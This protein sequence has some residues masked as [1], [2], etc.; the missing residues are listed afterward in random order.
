[1][2]RK[3][4]WGILGAGAIVDRWIKG[5]MQFDDMEIVAISSRTRETAEN[6]AKKWNIP[7]V[8]TYDEMVESPEIEIVYVP[9][10]HTAHKELA[11]KAMNAG[12]H[13]LVE[14]PAAINAKQFQE[15]MEC[16]EKNHVF[17]MEAVWT[18]F[19]PIINKALEIVKE[20]KIGDI[21]TIESTF[22][23]RTEDG[24]TSRLTDIERAGG[25]LLD[26]G[27]YNLHLAEMF[28]G[29]APVRLLGLASMDT[30]EY[31]IQVDEQAAY[32]GQYDK[33]ELSVLM[34]GIRTNTLHTAFIYGTKGHIVIPTFWKPWEMEVCVGEVTE[35]IEMPVSQNVEGVTDEG[36]Q[37]EIAYVNDCIRDGVKQSDMVPWKSTLDVLR[38]M[39]K[40]RYDWGLA[41]PGER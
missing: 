12:K 23:F 19:F 13:V 36:Y 32:I 4:K 5:A 25:G 16:A 14:K 35:K 8:M 40:L 18:R 9:V 33:G 34:S 17:L 30:D 15:M 41:Y 26:V 10:P 6:Q 39:D 11:I 38:Q 31:H 1:M 22:S 7:K 28:Y 29:K 20:G 21:R 27:V 24:D 3:V 37:Y 2:K